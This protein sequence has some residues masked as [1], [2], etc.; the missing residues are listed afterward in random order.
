VYDGCIASE[1]RSDPNR[2]GC[3]LVIDLTRVTGFIAGRRYNMVRSP[4]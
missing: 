4:D 2:L 3:A 1:Q